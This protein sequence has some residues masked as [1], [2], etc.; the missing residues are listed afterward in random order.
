MLILVPYS[1]VCP[2]S[3][4]QKQANADSHLPQG[5]GCNNRVYYMATV[6]CLVHLLTCIPV[7][8]RYP[9]SVICPI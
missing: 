9:L 3:P 2:R 5:R 7:N 1:Q 8:P 4:K 6:P